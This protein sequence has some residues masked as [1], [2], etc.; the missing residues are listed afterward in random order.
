MPGTGVE[1]F[2]LYRDLPQDDLLNEE[3][4][5]EP[6]YDQTIIRYVQKLK[7]A[8]RNSVEPESM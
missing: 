4:K 1:Y 7:R 5:D 6:T 2:P 8:L 3:R